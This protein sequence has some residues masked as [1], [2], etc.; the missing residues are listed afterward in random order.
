MILKSFSIILISNC[1]PPKYNPSF[2]YMLLF[3]S[4]IIRL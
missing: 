2:P 3:K 1:A 4:G